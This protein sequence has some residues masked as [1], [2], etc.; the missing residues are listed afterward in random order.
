MSYAQA[1]V[2]AQGY[3]RV[4]LKSDG[5]PPIIALT[6]LLVSRVILKG[7]PPCDHRTKGAAE[8]A[9]KDIKRRPGRSFSTSS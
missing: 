2:Q 3:R 4:I 6:R 5:E 7:S 9:V 8:A 1:L